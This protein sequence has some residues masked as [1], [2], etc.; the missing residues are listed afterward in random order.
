MKDNVILVGFMGAGKTAVGKI[1]AE[2]LKYQFIDTD[3]LIEKKSKMTINEIFSKYGEEAFRKMESELL[4]EL[5]N[6]LNH[7]VVSTGGGL[8]L[9]EENA[10]LLKTLGYVN[11]LKVSKDVALDRL[12]GDTTRPLLKGDN[13]EEKIGNLLAVR[14]PLYKA[15]SHEVVDVDF[16]SS[17]EVAERIIEKLQTMNE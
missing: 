9:R 2:R 15:A 11:F 16:S 10:S 13:L 3:E 17:K 4:V 8:P 7:S 1:I 14:D 6:N 5:N 12:K